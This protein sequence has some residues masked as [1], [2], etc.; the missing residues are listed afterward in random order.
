MNLLLEITQNQMS[1]CTA[2]IGVG[3]TLLGTLLGYVLSLLTRWGY[4]RILLQE[5]KFS[6]DYGFCNGAR[7]YDDEPN[8]DG[9]TPERTKVEIQLLITNPSDVSFNM[10]SLSLIFKQNKNSKG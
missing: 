2:L 8:V 9:K 7:I 5:I 10:N 6:Y 1:L 3:G 4:R